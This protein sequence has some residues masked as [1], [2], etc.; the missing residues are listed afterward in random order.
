MRA[1]QDRFGDERRQRGLAL[2]IHG[3]AAFAGEG[4]VQETLNLSQLPAYTVGG[5]LHVIVNNQLGFTTPP[6]QGRSS[7]YATDVAKLLQSPIFHVNGEQP[8]SVAQVVKLAMDF[9]REFRRDVIIDMYC[10]RLRGHNEGDEPAFTQ[11]LMYQQIAQ[12]PLV[13]DSYRRHLLSLG[14]VSEDEALALEAASRKRLEEEF[15]AAR[16]NDYVPAPQAFGGIWQDYRGGRYAEAGDVD[17]RTD[18]ERLASLLEAQTRLPADFHPHP[19]IERALK[20]RLQMA[21]SEHPLDWSAAE[22]L[23]FATLATEGYRV[24][25][26]GQDSQRGTFSQRH[27][28]LHDYKDGHTYVPLEHLADDQAQVEIANS[29]LSEAGVLG[30]EYGYSLD[31]P[32]GLIL[33]EAQ[34]GDFV[35]AAQVIIDQ[36]LTSAED[37]WRRLSGLVLLLPHGFE[38]QGPEHSSARLERFLAM[39]AEDNIQVASPSTPAQYYHLLRR[40]GLWKWRKPLVVM[41][42]KSL[43][44]RPQSTSTLEELADGKFEGVI[45]DALGKGE[46]AERIL[47]CTGKVYYDLLQAREERQRSDVPIMR[48]EQLYPPPEDQLRAALTPFGEGTPAFWVQ[49]EPINMGAWQYLR[50]RS[51]EALFGR[52]PLSCIARP[53][54]AS[55][56][57]GSKSSHQREQERL[58]A[59]AFGD[60][61]R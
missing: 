17:T 11:P 32:D 27:A 56:A 39:C 2:L 48:I 20:T 15:E 25:L 53:E 4:V 49:E 57:T 23:A 7:I 60:D 59:R 22:S 40:Q 26:T 43:L 3:D 19:K 29:P 33:W 31:W 34:F 13:R 21:A 1:K 8:E 46:A 51:G 16:S 24:R 54:S 61:E 58:I 42:P 44:R 35:N 14:G 47:L 30:F 10:Y 55:P 36:F 9:R 12:R 45:P 37:K 28:V 50:I 38:G 18:R 5:T 52:W 41:T 6:A